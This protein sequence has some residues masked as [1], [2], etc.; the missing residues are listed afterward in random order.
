[1]RI[2]ERVGIS[3]AAIGIP[4]SAYL[5]IG[6][7]TALGEAYTLATTADSFIPFGAVWVVPYIY[8]Y[9]SASA[10]AFAV[11]DRRVLI[12]WAATVALMYMLAA[13]IWIMYPVTVPRPIH[14]GEDYFSYLLNL[15]QALDPPTN[16]FPSMHVAVATVAGLVV[17]RVDKTIG[18]ILL[19]SVLPIWY[20]TVAVGQH[21]I[22]DGGAGL[23]LALSSFTIVYG[24]KPLPIS[25][26]ERIPRFAH[27]MWLGLLL[28][29]LAS[30][31]LMWKLGLP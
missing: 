18:T 2:E 5:L 11:E 16:C 30:L 31:S 29:A 14:L 10:P 17:R 7:Q 15:I 23:V 24:W 20:S 12:R 25:A 13:P 1:M 28:S 21:W 22:V 9:I 26:F 6:N 19:L 8:M 3:A 4:L 27:L